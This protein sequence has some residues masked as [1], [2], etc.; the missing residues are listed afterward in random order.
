MTFTIKLLI[1]IVGFLL[2]IVTTTFLAILDY[3]ITMY[4]LP[5]DIWQI[6]EEHN[7]RE[8]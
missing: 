4:H 1:W 6:I 8:P 5:T 3:I 7:I 2:S